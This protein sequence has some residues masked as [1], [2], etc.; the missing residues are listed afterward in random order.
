[1]SGIQDMRQQRAAKAAEM[2]ALV[3]ANRGKQWNAGLDKQF[4][5]MEREVI[6]ID[7][8]I[9]RYSRALDAVA[10]ELRA[11][12]TMGGDAPSNA[13]VGAFG[14]RGDRSGFGFQNALTEG[15]DSGGVLVP[16]EIA[17]QVMAVAKRYS[18]LRGLCTVINIKTAASKY[19]QPIVTDGAGAGWVGEETARPSTS[20]P[21]I[22]GVT[23]PDGE[24]Y[25]N[26]PLSAW[27]DEDTQAGNIIVT[28]IGKA[29]GRQE[30]DAFINGNGTNKPFG[31]LNGTPT[32]EDDASRAM[33]VLQYIA[34][35]EAAAITADSLISMVYS[36]LPEYRVNGAWVMN[37][38]TVATVRK[39]KNSVGD[40]LWSD[41]LTPGQPAMLLGY[42]VV[43]CN[44]LPDVAAGTFPIA[45]GDFMSGYHILDRSMV[46]LRDP[47]TSKPFI[48]IY[49][50]KRVSGNIVD[51]NAIKLLKIAA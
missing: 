25:A 13:A 22:E 27:L 24:V 10:G 23:F 14:I 37:S 49:S 29:F 30:G 12:S 45:F 15:A 34:S 7:G 33:G 35:G 2:Q 41:A 18:P 6:E 9:E 40:Y 21:K 11:G 42:K 17:S 48:N 5:A 28:E 50:R 19:S 51:S 1:M 26:V 43:E 4:N 8:Q 31:I 47:F 20:V 44:N 38:T 3:E 32:V 16:T 39:L 46:M 36:L